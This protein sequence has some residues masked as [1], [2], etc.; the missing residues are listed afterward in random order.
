MVQVA[1]AQHNPMG[2]QQREVTVLPFR[3]WKVLHGENQDFL[4][5][6]YQWYIANG[7]VRADWFIGVL[8]LW[9][10]GCTHNPNRMIAAVE[11][12]IR[13]IVQHIRRLRRANSEEW[14]R[15]TTFMNNLRDATSDDTPADRRV[16]LPAHLADALEYRMSDMENL[17]DIFDVS[18][19]IQNVN[20]SI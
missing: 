3:I 14:E 16:M 19:N 4:R 9:M 20:W 1:P 10:P 17:A 18:G 13:Q 12:F 7:Q 15:L 6:M 5:D 11:T 2:Q 8:P